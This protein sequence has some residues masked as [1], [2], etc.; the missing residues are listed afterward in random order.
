MGA[1]YLSKNFGL[2][3][4]KFPLSNATVFSRLSD[5][6][7]FLESSYLKFS[8]P[9]ECSVEC[10][11]FVAREHVLW[12][13]MRRDSVKKTPHYSPL[14]CFTG[15]AGWASSQD[16]LFRTEFSVSV[17]LLRFE[18]F[19]IVIWLNEKSPR[20]NSPSASGP[21]LHAH[22]EWEKPKWRRGRR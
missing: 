12:S 4:W 20:F 17:P 2:N 11:A 21:K 8:V 13:R 7:D 5:F 1:F 18:M 19:R 22:C 10:F 16:S 15:S 3:S 9:W 6:P 14:G